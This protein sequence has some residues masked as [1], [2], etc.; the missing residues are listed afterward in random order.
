M[1]P[2]ILA[3]IQPPALVQLWQF[4]AAYAS[5]YTREWWPTDFLDHWRT[6]R[7]ALIASIRTVFCQ[8]PEYAATVERN[9]PK[10]AYLLHGHDDE[11]VRNFGS[12]ANVD[13]VNN[14]TFL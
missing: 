14:H 13:E 2:F 7:T 12:P 9:S 4:E 5:E 8:I 6:V 11:D 10:F 3:P 1:M